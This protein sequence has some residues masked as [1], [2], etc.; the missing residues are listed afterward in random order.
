MGTLGLLLLAAVGGV[1]LAARVPV[2]FVVCNGYMSTDRA[3]KICLQ[4]YG[5][6][7]HESG[8][9]GCRILVSALWQFYVTCLFHKPKCTVVWVTFFLQRMIH[10]VL[11]KWK[12]I[13]PHVSETAY[14]EILLFD[15]HS[16][17]V[18]EG[19]HVLPRVIHLFRKHV[20][21]LV[22]RDLIIY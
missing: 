6:T 3:L 5:F 9:K 16:S 15:V 18:F 11:A 19:R 20:K 4:F 8:E 10:F 2:T 22:S 12:M 17:I 13:R 14:Y 21:S 1:G 7:M